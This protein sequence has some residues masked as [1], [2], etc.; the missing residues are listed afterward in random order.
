MPR[1]VKTRSQKV[2][3]P[4]GTPM[5]VGKKRAEG[6]KITVLNY[7]D[8]QFREAEVQTVDECLPFRDSPTVT[9][10]NVDGV[11]EVEI[12]ERLGE[13][14][15][16]HPLVV[17]DIVN[18]DQRPK[19]EDYGDYLYIVLKML[20]YDTTGKEI[21]TEQTSLIL[22]ER[23]VIS[24]QEREGDVLDP[25][26]E[27]ITSNK[28]RIRKMGAD[29]LAYTLIDAIVDN[30]FFVVESLGEE[31]DLLE[32]E[33]VTNPTPETLQTIH[34]LKREMVF[35]RKSVWPL[36]EVIGTLERGESS[37]MRESTGVYLRDVYDHTI[38]VID[39]V[40]TLRDIVSGMLDI[41]L[42]SISNRMNEVMKV[43]TI[44]ATIF[45]PLTLI[46]GIYGMNFR[47]MP[48]LGWR[49]GYLMVWLVM[50]GV[51]SS[52]VVY[53]KRRTWL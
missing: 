11:H 21:I 26:R 33:L 6:A 42:S 22:G 48:E 1:V 12:L 14:F 44:I 9:W 19:V 45:I 5:H 50:L 10:I 41:Y 49:W 32:E 16:L 3:L 25:I 53:F 35:L 39:A 46:V 37:L 43:L 23:Y 15:G 31:V 28:G 13:C 34:E 20:H 7:D 29:Y 24:F 30:Y 2:G 51:G 47:Y 52:M 4:P 27:R 38:Q 8:A 17:E 40:E 18:T 36:R